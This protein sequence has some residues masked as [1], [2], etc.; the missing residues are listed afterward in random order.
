MNE[1]Q[2]LSDA[3]ENLADGFSLTYVNSSEGAGHDYCAEL[4]APNGERVHLALEVKYI[5]RKQTLLT[6]KERM[7]HDAGGL[8]WLLVCNRLTPDLAAFCA[9]QKINYLDSAGNTRIQVPGLY[10]MVEGRYEK[11]TV[12]SGSKMAEGVM[13]LLFVLLSDP[14]TLNNTYRSLAEL[15][16]ISLGMV[17]KAFGYLENQ[18][19]YR[20]A[21]GGRRLMK[22]DE[23]VA[24]WINDY[25]NALRPKLKQL[26]ADFPKSWEQ[27]ALLPDEY[28]GGEIVAAELSEGYLLPST[29]IVYT[30]YPLLQRRKELGLKPARDGHFQLITC[31]WG[32]FK[33]NTRAKTILCLAELLGSGDDRNREVARIINDK[34]LNLNESA[35]FSY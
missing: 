6:A 9:S 8:P 26:Y 35:L 31:F 29:G 14:D 11:K 25:A 27:L 16:G 30:P 12:P 2:L 5:H 20:K 34:Y 24:L 18:R 21:Q 13:K 33:L 19:Y 7:T 15:S 4:I 23:L 28:S 3:I 17:S 1:E 22:E 32:G 10:L